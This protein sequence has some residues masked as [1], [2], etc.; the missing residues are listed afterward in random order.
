M[1]GSDI[2][3]LLML[4]ALSVVALGS[5]GDGVEGIWLNEDG[6]GWIELRLTDG[7]LRGVIA[8][9]PDDP[10]RLK[11]SRLDVENPD[12][13]LRD[14]ELYG[15]QILLGFR[16]ETENRWGGGRIYDPNTGNTYRGTLTLVDPHT[17]KLR[18]FIGFSLFGRSEIW[19]RRD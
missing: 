11:P 5:D 14:R 18:G 16:Q 10:Q 1:H 4:C 17:L 15:L 13:A 7:E 12:P 19:T 9:S 3:S 8:G 6:D 2:C